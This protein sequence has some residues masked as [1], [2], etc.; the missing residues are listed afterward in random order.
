MMAA[1]LT[2]TPS[3][4]PFPEGPGP[5]V[6][7][8]RLHEALKQLKA[9][10]ASPRAT[11]KAEI[12]R[13]ESA[14]AFASP[15]AAQ[16]PTATAPPTGAL[17]SA[18]LAPTIKPLP[19]DSK[20][21]SPA[22]LTAEPAGQKASTVASSLAKPLLAA[23]EPRPV[24]PEV[25]FSPSQLQQF[26][27]LTD[28]LVGQ[29]P[30][31]SPLALALAAADPRQELAYVASRL[32]LCLAERDAGEV[33]LIEH[34]LATR[35]LANATLISGLADVATGRVELSQ[36]IEPAAV[37]HLSL[38]GPSVVASPEETPL[39]EQWRATM[40]QC[41]QHF[42]FIVASVRPHCGGHDPWLASF[43]GIYLV[44]NLNAT[45]QGSALQ[46]LARLKAN[47]AVVQ[48][49]IALR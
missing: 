17:L 12:V 24:C 33:L 30:D 38:L 22:S 1:D 31:S 29:R 5:D 8:S 13:A 2:G 15:A 4:Q 36:A 45:A 37:R 28:N 49:C 23:A 34:D 25:W 47:G 44:I 21:L 6:R 3:P 10:G 46:T 43:D 39:S 41:K 40:K 35:N 7:M 11:M 32:A 9:K 27:C 16:S 18:P 20:I 26:R 14:P 19:V 42:R 48:G